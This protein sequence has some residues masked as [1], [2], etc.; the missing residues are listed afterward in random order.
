MVEKCIAVAQ[1]GTYLCD[2][3]TAIAAHGRRVVLRVWGTTVVIHATPPQC[4]SKAHMTKVHR[5][6]KV[7]SPHDNDTKIRI[8]DRN[9]CVP[10][11]AKANVL[12]RVRRVW[13]DVSTVKLELIGEPPAQ[14]LQ[15][16]GWFE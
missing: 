1:R 2:Y 5:N 4:D 9:R 12:S 13:T 7:M 3:H 16:R 11:F 8:R 14:G 10:E 6:R 15:V